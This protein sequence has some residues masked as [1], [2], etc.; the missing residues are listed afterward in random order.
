MLIVKY[1]CVSWLVIIMIRL[2]VYF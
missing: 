2:V 1:P